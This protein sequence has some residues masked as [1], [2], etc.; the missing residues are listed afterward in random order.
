MCLPLEAAD[1]ETRDWI[2]DSGW[3]FGRETLAPYYER[4][5]E[6]IGL[7]GVAF[8]A[9]SWS[10][11]A[12]PQLAKESGLDTRMIQVAPTRF[13]D[14]HRGSLTSASN[15]DAYLNANLVDIELGPGESRVATLH[16]ETLEH[17]RIRVR[18]RVVVLAAGGIENPRL[19]L[20]SNRQQ[21][22]GLGNQHDLVGRY[23]TEHP[24][25]FAS[26]FLP[27]TSAER[28]GLYHPAS[29]RKAGGVAVIG[30]WKLSDAIRRS[31]RL[32]D[33]TSWLSTR[34]ESTSF[35]QQLGGPI[36]EM[37]AYPPSAPAG[38]IPTPA[39]Y[40]LTSQCE[41]TPNSQSRVR[42][43]NDLDALGVPRVELDWRLSSMD[44]S[45]VRRTHEMIARAVGEAGVGRLKLG[46]AEG[47]EW[48]ENMQGGRHHM[49]TTRMHRDP[50]KG[51]VDSDGRVHGLANLYIAGSSVFPTV[52][53]ANP[54]LTIVALAVRLADHLKGVVQ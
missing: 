37:D 4:A 15:I 1:F 32:A 47:A 42:L 16:V 34:L 2:P 38:P 53:A 3:P 49:G 30:A 12:R 23:F 13:G 28:L 7:D 40:V 41:Q 26:R 6:I 27:S 19:L 29:R 33:C 48:P 22:L 51:V 39:T 35:E 43:I 46:L 44:Y 50:R 31:H 9:A 20:A 11:D 18:P 45:S 25:V 52:G 21:A 10:D 5:A 54:T 14:V 8:D 17:R 36:V 24:H